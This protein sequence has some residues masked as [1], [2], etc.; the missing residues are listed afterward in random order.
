M[1]A[2]GPPGPGPAYS[3]RPRKGKGAGDSSP[4][5]SLGSLAGSLVA[6]GAAIVLA[7]VVAAVTV[8]VPILVLAVAVAPAAAVTHV[9]ENPLLEAGDAA[10]DGLRFPRG[11]A[12]ASE[13]RQ[14]ALEVARLRLQAV[15]FALADRIAA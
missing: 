2:G 4:A 6:A 12:V 3:Q 9:A 10:L 13:D 5:P 7:P 1:A 11:Q 8:A 15:G 14:P